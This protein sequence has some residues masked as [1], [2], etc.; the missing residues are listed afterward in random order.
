MQPSGIAQ[1]RSF[2]V[3]EEGEID[4]TTGY[5]AEDE[6]GGAEGF[7]EALEDVF[8]FLMTLNTHGINEGSKEDKPD[9]AKVKER[10]KEKEKAEEEEDTSSQEDPKAEEKEE[11]KAALT[12]WKKKDIKK[13][14]K[15]KKIGMIPGMKATGPMNKTGMMAIGPQKNCTT[16]MSMVIHPASRGGA[17]HTA[18]FFG[19]LK[20]IHKKSIKNIVFFSVFTMC[21]VE[22]HRNLRGFRHKV[23]P[24]QW[25]LQCFQCS[26]I[27]KLQNIAIY[28]VFSFLSVFHL[29]EADQN[30]PKF[31]FNTLL[32]SD[33]QKSSKK[34]K[35]RKHHQYEV[36]VRNR[37]CPPQLK[38]I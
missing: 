25:F 27:Q 16:R 9:E 31:R 29:P 18:G 5:C 26:G 30:D 2:L 17:A 11:E 38:L 7:L 33:T 4:G 3:L 8:W 12:W 1:R 14:G 36:S 15:K 24:K 35:T 13:T 6:G 32:S 10:E 37:F 28:S 21:S 34:Q 19:Q 23:G 20:H 22:K